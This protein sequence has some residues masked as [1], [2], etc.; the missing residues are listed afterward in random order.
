MVNQVLGEAGT[1]I[2]EAMSR[3]AVERGAINLGQGF[4]EGFEPPELLDA[5]ARALRE[6]SQQYPPMMGLPVLRQAVA[7]NARRFLGIDVNWE[8][9]C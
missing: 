3:L 5:A 6:T 9:K 7:E 8:G 4:P 1:S 2:F